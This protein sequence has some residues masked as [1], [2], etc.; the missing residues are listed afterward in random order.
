MFTICFF[1]ISGPTHSLAGYIP[2]HVSLNESSTLKY[3]KLLT[4][5]CFNSLSVGQPVL[6][7]PYAA[8]RSLGSPRLPPA[9]WV[10]YI[11]SISK[12]ESI[13]HTHSHTRTCN[14][15]QLYQ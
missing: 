6:P 9:R 10:A 12:Q 7:L 2:S 13:S 11:L 8:A 3:V 5:A 15:L 14:R 4:H 1:L